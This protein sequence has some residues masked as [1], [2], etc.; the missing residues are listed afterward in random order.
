MIAIRR[1]SEYLQELVDG[2]DGLEK[3][4]LVAED[5]H[6]VNRLKDGTGV[7]L[8]AVIPNAQRAGVQGT[9]EDM[10]STIFFVLEKRSRDAD[11]AKELDQYEKTQDIILQI[12]EKIED[13]AEEGCWPFWRLETASIA[14]E[15]EYN[16][17]GGWNGW[18]MLL[19][20]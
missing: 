17:F 14:I 16:V 4:H 8:V 20:F 6:A 7:H 11:D 15:P 3:F 9:G 12:R 1:F 10:N 13:D 5:N 18:S 2:I 19:E